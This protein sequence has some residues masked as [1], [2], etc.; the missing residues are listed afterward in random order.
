MGGYPKWVQMCQNSDL[1]VFTGVEQKG[2][3][4]WHL[5]QFSYVLMILNNLSVTLVVLYFWLEN[6]FM[7]GQSYHQHIKCTTESSSLAHL[8][9]KISL[10]PIQCTLPQKWYLEHLSCKNTTPRAI[11]LI[12]KFGTK[13]VC[14]VPFQLMMQNLILFY[15]WLFRVTLVVAF[16]FLLQ[17]F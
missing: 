17:K 7:K 2:A 5:G 16:G 12:L 10:L 14:C 15:W 6:V 1:G 9:T 11:W 13:E 3:F 8:G 4:H